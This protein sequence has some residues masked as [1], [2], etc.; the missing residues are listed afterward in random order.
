MEYIKENVINKIISNRREVINKIINIDYKDIEANVFLYKKHESLN[1][2][3]ELFY[4]A[5]NKSC[6][7]KELIYN[8]FIEVTKNF[9]DSCY[10]NQYFE[11]S[12]WVIHLETFAT[13]KEI[14]RKAL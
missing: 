2:F 7:Q 9:I 6:N 4:I 1:L 3:Q 10:V 5:Y 11:K 13:L 8:N 14:I 12:S